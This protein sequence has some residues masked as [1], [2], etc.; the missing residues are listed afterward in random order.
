MNAAAR[1][2]LFETLAE[3]AR[4]HPDWRMGQLVANVAEWANQGVWDVEDGSLLAAA[5]LH[6]EQLADSTAEARV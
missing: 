2:E 4:R 1:S 3:L 6:L 5:R